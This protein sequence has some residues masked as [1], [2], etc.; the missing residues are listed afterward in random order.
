MTSFVTDPAVFDRA[1]EDVGNIVEFGHLNLRVP[2]QLLATLFYL[3]GLGFTRDPYLA[4]GTDNMWV[5]AG[6]GQFHLPTGPAQILRGTVGLVVPELDALRSRLHAVALRLAGTRFAWYD[7]GDAIDLT[8]PWGNRL[9]AHA[10]EEGRF[11][12]I[13][14]GVPYVEL[15]AP[16]GSAG[17]IA[18][19]YR[20]TLHGLAVTGEDARGRFARVVAGPGTALVFRETNR[21]AGGEDGPHVQIT[22][23]DFSGPYR[24]LLARGLVTEE[25][26]R[27]QYRF[28]DVVDPESGEV[29]VTIGHE[30]RSLRHPLYGRVLVNRH[31]ELTGDRYASGHEVWPV[32]MPPEDLSNLV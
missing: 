17:A 18:G 19:F 2:D 20:E 15:D 16:A 7:A 29:L 28:Q 8:C 10:P 22:V 6:A 21:L 30:V 14:L 23:A 32:A 26:N 25:S 5:N 24:R 11:G 27:H 12:R 3:M 4:V 31:A 13:T 9:R 1:A